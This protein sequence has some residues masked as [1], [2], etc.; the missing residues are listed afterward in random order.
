MPTTRY[1]FSTHTQDDRDIIDFLDSFKSRDRTIIVKEAIRLYMEKQEE[2]ETIA[3]FDENKMENIE[4]KLSEIFHELMEIKRKGLQ[5]PSNS[6]K[7]NSD[8]VIDED[9]QFLKNL[10][11]LG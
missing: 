11:Q 9:E 2:L 7:I 3:K 10:D 1:T 5:T 8:T 4:N 6:D